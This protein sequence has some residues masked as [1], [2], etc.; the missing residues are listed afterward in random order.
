MIA[1]DLSK[2]V[3]VAA[4]T[5]A[6]IHRWGHL[7]QRAAIEFFVAES[8]EPAESDD[9]NH[10]EIW[11]MPDDAEQARCEFRSSEKDGRKSLW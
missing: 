9:S 7:L 3:V 2:L 8:V 4:G 11:V 5:S 1:Q 10:G 6:Q